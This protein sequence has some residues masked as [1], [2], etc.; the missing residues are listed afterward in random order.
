MLM[1]FKFQ[2]ESFSYY[3]AFFDYTLNLG[4]EKSLYINKNQYSKIELL[5]EN[6]NK[7]LQNSFPSW[8]S[9]FFD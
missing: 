3:I 7:I 9:I 6:K 5:K 4:S 8:H 2:R 1:L